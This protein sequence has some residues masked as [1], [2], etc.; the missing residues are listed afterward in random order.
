MQCHCLARIEESE[1]KIR[2]VE[3]VPDNLVYNCGLSNPE[4]FFLAQGIPCEL[5]LKR[6][7]VPKNNKVKLGGYLLFIYYFQNAASL[8]FLRY[9]L[10]LLFFMKMLI[11]CCDLLDVILNQDSH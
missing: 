7:T 3:S 1:T 11:A 5:P 6:H 10:L 4:L 8:N 9:S 2:K